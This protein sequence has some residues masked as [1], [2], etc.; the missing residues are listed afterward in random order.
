MTA[1]MLASMA[2]V[3]IIAMAAVAITWLATKGTDSQHRAT[4]VEN[5]AQVVRAIRGRR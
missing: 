4:V 2:M 5:I 3:L 1:L